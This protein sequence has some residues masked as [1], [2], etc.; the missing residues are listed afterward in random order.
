MPFANETAGPPALFGRDGLMRAH[1]CGATAPFHSCH[2]RGTGQAVTR[3]GRSGRYPQ[4]VIFPREAEHRATPVFAAASSA[5]DARRD[6]TDILNS[7]E[8]SSAVCARHMVLPIPCNCWPKSV[9]RRIGKRGLAT[10]ADSVSPADPP[11]FAR[12][13][14]MTA[15]NTEVR[16]TLRR[17]KGRSKKRLRVPSK[18]DPYLATIENWLAVEPQLTALT[19][20]R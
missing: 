15:T 16:A 3:H 12:S 5:I 6:T 13:L 8:R 18:L 19:I 11:A 4:K 20:V 1:G 2:C 9:W 17:P 10:A 7:H 14:G